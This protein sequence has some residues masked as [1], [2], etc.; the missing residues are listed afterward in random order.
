M[1]RPPEHLRRSTTVIKNPKRTKT[2]S[3]SLVRGNLWFFVS[4]GLDRSNEDHN[5]YLS[6]S[7]IIIIYVDDLLLFPSDM[8]DITEMKSVLSGQL[9]MSD[10]DEIW[11]FLG[12]HVE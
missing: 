7:L 12:L 4:F 8:C 5:M 10:L 2:G 1:S 11:Q 3:K 6:T 9:E